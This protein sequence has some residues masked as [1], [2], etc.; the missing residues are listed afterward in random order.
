[1]AHFAVHRSM[2]SEY[3]KIVEAV[4]DLY[5][6]DPSHLTPGTVCE[7]A[8]VDQKVFDH[9]FDSVNDA[10]KAWYPL[11]V[12]RVVEQMTGV[13]DI[14]T[15]S[16]Q[17]RLGTFCF[18]LLDQLESR[19][20]FVRPTFRYHAACFSAPL[21][22]RLREALK[23]ELSAPDVP[24]VNYVVLDTD[25]SRF[26]IAESIVQMISVWLEDESADRERATALIDRVL[27][28]V[29]TI[30]TNPIPQKTVD[31]IRYAVEAGY[32]PLDRLP[33]V[34]D[35]FKTADSESE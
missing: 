2:L 17:D 24:G 21:H 14:D 15:L 10:I 18:M 34:R 3:E 25:A 33:F 30:A 8:G 27:A 28:L 26:V 20:D 1:M 5:V 29:A 22:G 23:N 19:M 7:L 32:L 12:D 35:L 16:L 13:P 4:V 31:L 9:H 6:E 11:A